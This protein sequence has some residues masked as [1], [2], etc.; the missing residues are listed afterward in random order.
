MAS[1]MSR[2]IHA[3]LVTVDKTDAA[4]CEFILVN[5]GGALYDPDA[6]RSHQGR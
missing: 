2:V 6:G 3:R 1:S 4:H 5:F